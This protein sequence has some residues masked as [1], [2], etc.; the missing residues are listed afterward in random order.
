MLMLVMF[1]A[2]E[3][4]GGPTRHPDTHRGPA[5]PAADRDCFEKHQIQKGTHT[6]TCI[7]I[8]HQLFL[9]T[10]FLYLTLVIFFSYFRCNLNT[11]FF[12]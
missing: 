2:Q 11:V 5:A 7:L 10:K 1:M 12:Y 6:V 8:V 9:V 3:S 4:H